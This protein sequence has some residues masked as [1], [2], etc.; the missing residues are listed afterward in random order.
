MEAI[1]QMRADVGRNNTLYVHVTY[2]NPTSK[3]GELKPSRRSISVRE[4]RSIGIQPD[5]ILAPRRLRNPGKNIC[6]NRTVLQCRRRGRH[7]CCHQRSFVW[8]SA[9]TGSGRRGRCRHRSPGPKCR[10]QAGIERMGN[11]VAGD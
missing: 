2:L 6:K 9:G 1:R 4:L 10:Q 7:S 8:H 3:R 11:A 5:V